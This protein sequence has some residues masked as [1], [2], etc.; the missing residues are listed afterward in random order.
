MYLVALLAKPS[1]AVALL[2]GKNQS[3]ADKMLRGIHYQ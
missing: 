3:K 2:K 1:A